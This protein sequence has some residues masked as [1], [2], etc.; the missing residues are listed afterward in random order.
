MPLWFLA[1]LS[2][3][4]TPMKADAVEADLHLIGGTV[5]V[6]DRSQAL[7]VDI[8]I[9]GDQIIFVGHSGK[10]VRARRTIDVS[11]LIVAPGFI[12][13]HTHAL[14]DLNS[15]DESKRRNTNY[16]LQGVTTVFIGNDGGGSS[17]VANLS[18]DLTAK[19]I[20]INAAMFVGHG[21]VRRAVMGDAKRKPTDVELAQMKVLVRT[22]MRDGAVGLS[23]G[24]FYAPGSFSET[25][26][27]VEL[28]KAAAEGGGVYDSH[29]RD[30]SNYNIGLEAAIDEALEIG[31]RANIPVNISHIKALGVD[32]WGRSS[33]II[34]KIEAA[35]S[36]GLKVTA[37][38]Y[39]WKAS[40]TSLSSALIPSKMK[41]GGK[42]ALIARLTNPKR[43]DQLHKDVANN[44]LRRGGP[45]SILITEGDEEWKGLTLEQLAA[46]NN[47]SPVEMAI[48][49]VRKG[50]TKIASFNMTEDDIMNYMRQ[51]WVM[52]GSDGGGGHPRKYGSFPEKYRKYVKQRG[53]LST[54]DFIYQSS[55]LA[56]ETFG[57]CD[58]GF[59]REG[60]RA[61]IVI[62]D[63][64]KFRAKADYQN[65]ERQSEGIE[66]LIVN[67]TVAVDRGISN[68]IL[69]GRTLRPCRWRKDR[70]S[71]L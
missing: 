37:D 16:R 9:R 30:E 58:R 47:V 52:T 15:A 46:K 62:F 33:G 69:S 67:G 31:R 38:Q 24:L 29:I 36:S 8:V 7:V 45:G 61:D 60:Y 71:P 19:G 22:A 2:G 26:E 40:S 20:G 59:L 65:P 35:R 42:A 32:V 70:K 18:Q 41:A 54:E 5:H 53:V 12:D 43:K 50:D 3:C 48:E 10:R 27:I 23:T 6:G 17:A 55:G 4:A 57:L 44:L 56:A 39:P 49:I 11:G 21:A 68:R 13:P 34:A 66:Y 14:A 25:D 28:A 1:G 64:E 51:K 63:P